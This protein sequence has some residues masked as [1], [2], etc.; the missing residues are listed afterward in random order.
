MWVKSVASLYYKPQERWE[1]YISVH[2]EN[3]I[4]IPSNRKVKQELGSCAPIEVGHRKGGLS[5][6]YANIH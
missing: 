6:L 2:T 4:E 1:H 3:E 5:C